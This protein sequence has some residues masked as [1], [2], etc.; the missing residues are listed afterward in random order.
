MQTFLA[1]VTLGSSATF[2]EF[3]ATTAFLRIF[4]DSK[5]RADVCLEK[6]I[7]PKLPHTRAQPGEEFQSLR[8]GV[9]RFGK[10]SETRARPCERKRILPKL[11]HTRARRSE[12]F[13]TCRTRLPRIG[14]DS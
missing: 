14:N 1:C 4:E 11:P 9:R 6:R 3:E 2:H 5:V 10:D 13:Q 12:E 7:L 8:T